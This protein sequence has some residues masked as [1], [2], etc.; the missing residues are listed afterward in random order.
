[1]KAMTRSTAGPRNRIAP[2]L[3]IGA[4]ILLVVAV[5]V[6]LSVMAGNP[7]GHWSLGAARRSLT[8][9]QMFDSAL[10]S[11][12]LV[13]CA[14]ALAWTAWTWM[15]ICVALEVKGWL[16]GRSTK[17]LPASRTLQS[18]AAC[19][20]GTALAMSSVGRPVPGPLIAAIGHA[21]QSVTETRSDITGHGL[22]GGVIPIIEDRFSPVETA[23]A[24]TSMDAIVLTTPGAGGAASPDRSGAVPIDSTEVADANGDTRKIRV[25]EYAERGKRGSRRPPGPPGPPEGNPLVHRLVSA[26]LGEAVARDRPAQLRGR[27]VRREIAHR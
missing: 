10:V 14:V 18:V 4:L 15:T 20:V 21:N 13:R 1:M 2:W 24:P 23:H 27:A 19:L 12:W 3:A 7:F 9:K 26:R 5:P 11:H 6:V 22:V 17:S 16:T 25:A 8:S